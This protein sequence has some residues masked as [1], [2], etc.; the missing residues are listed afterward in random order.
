MARSLSIIATFALLLAAGTALAQGS[1]DARVRMG[2]RYFQQMA[3]AQAVE[4]YRIAAELG[5]VN[6]HVTKRLGDCYMK[7]GEPE[8]AVYWYSIVVKFLNRGPQ[9]MF[10]YAQALKSNG[11]YAE[12]E[13]WMDRYLA[14]TRDDGRAARSNIVGFAR[15]FSQDSERFV[16]RPVSIN[17]AYTEMSPVWF[18]EDRILFASSM[19]QTVGVRRVAAWNA[20]PFLDLYAARIM[21][22][23]DLQDPQPLQ[24]RVNSNMHDGPATADVQNGVL[25]FTRNDHFNGRTG[26]SRQ[27]VTKLNLYK[28]HLRNG[29]WNDIEQFLYNSSESSMGHPA[30]SPGGRKLFFVSDM[31]GGYGGTDIYVCREVDGHWGEPE[32]LGPLVNT[33]HDEMFPFVAA[34]GTLYFSSNGHPGLGGL[35]VFAAPPNADGSY[36]VVINLGAPVNSTHDDH[37]FIIDPVGK[38]GYFASNRPGGAGGDDLYTFEMLAPLEQRF[39]A[40]GTVIDDE[41][42]TPVIGIEVLLMDKSGNIIEATQ[43]DER[44]EYFFAVEKDK[45]YKLVSRM[46]GRYD[47]EHFLTT[48]RIETEQILSRDLHL[49]PDAGIWMRG[50]AR[51]KDRMGT[52]QGM[53]VSLVNLGSFYSEAVVTGEGGDFRF[54]LQPNEEFEVLFEKPGYFSMSV[55]V[56]TVGVKRGVIDL[57]Q[58]RDLSFEPIEIGKPIAF[59][60]IRW[61]EGGTNLDPVARTEIDALAERM[62]VNPLIN[63]EIGVHTDTRG[64]HSELRRL[65]QRR[66]DTI[67]EHLRAKGVPKDRIVGKGHGAAA[68][69]NHCLPGVQC[70]EEEHAQNRRNEYM[71][72]GLKETR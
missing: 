20:E 56:T 34:D 19:R 21:P 63:V 35:D 32:N 1:A 9:E 52:I 11:K 48:E 7:L 3:Y 45:E 26:R 59:K 55:P 36:Q 60:Y 15:K 33:P 47:A 67:V 61:P 4:H 12:A 72:T 5:A 43:T 31:P 39:L 65:S 2:D 10:N 50:V 17:T 64:D 68:P 16:V 53:T 69:L 23:G 18:G 66:A 71:V 38:R 51:Y 14:L 37:G 57:N 22:G 41:S 6:E 29:A 28:A 70:T 30:L 54:R 58:A 25:W 49:V 27:G 44:G 24:G 46:K 13:E 62:L 42:D 8:Q 40:M